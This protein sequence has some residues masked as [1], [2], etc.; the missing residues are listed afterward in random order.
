MPKDRTRS[1]IQEEIRNIEA[2]LKEAGTLQEKAQKYKYT[3][4]ITQLISKAKANLLTRFWNDTTKRD[5]LWD[6]LEHAASDN[7]CLL[8]Q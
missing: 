7:I 8:V 2:L 5:N 6:S 4:R 1:D 3:Q